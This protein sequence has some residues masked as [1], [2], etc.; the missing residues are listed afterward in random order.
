[1]NLTVLNRLPDRL[2]AKSIAAPW[3]TSDQTMI[4]DWNLVGILM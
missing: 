3:Q 2:F 4:N 1:M